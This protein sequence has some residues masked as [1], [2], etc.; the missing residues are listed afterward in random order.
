VSAMLKDKQGKLPWSTPTL[1][2]GP[3]PMDALLGKPARSTGC[4]PNFTEAEKQRL[5]ELF[6]ERALTWKAEHGGRLPT[7]KQS[8]GPA[9]KLVQDE[10]LESSD[11]I[12]ERQIIGPVLRELRA[13][14][15]SD[16]N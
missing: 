6:R 3:I 11:T 5:R 4:I 7:I 1:V 9:Q 10:G 14:K 16:R 8:V 15:R 13:K 2:A 12:L